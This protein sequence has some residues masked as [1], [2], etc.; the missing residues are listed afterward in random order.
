MKS[1]LAFLFGTIC[2]SLVALCV[3]V[4]FGEDRPQ[5]EHAAI[6]E[7][8]L[9]YIEGWYTADATRMEQA[10]YPE[11]AKRVLVRD[12][13]TGKGRIDHM[14]AMR[15]VQRTRAR[16]DKA[17]KLSDVQREVVILDV[18]ENA[19][20]VKVVGPDWVDY[21]HLSKLGG[22]WQIVNVLWEFNPATKERLGIPQEL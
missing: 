6:T 15:L 9:D 16:K 17:I 7:T 14:G 13:R 11:L 21:L 2:L 10:L 12:P 5:P 3:G 4:G 19:A 1:R 8:A 20:S 18:F 22:R